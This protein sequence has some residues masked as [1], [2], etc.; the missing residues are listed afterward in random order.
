MMPAL[1]GTRELSDAQPMGVVAPHGSRTRNISHE[2]RTPLSTILG[3][4]ELLQA[5]VYDAL[6]AE[7]DAA[8]RG[9]AEDGRHLLA[10]IGDILGLAHRLV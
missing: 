9:I 2:P 10:L 3:R 8:I 6:S 7:Q 1:A 5:Q 4:A